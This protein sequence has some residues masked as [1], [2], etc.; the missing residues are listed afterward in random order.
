MGRKL[1]FWQPVPATQ[2]V[3]NSNLTPISLVQQFCTPPS[4]DRPLGSF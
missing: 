4:W 1:T 3:S 2:W